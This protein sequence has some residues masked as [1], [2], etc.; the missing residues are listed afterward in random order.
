MGKIFNKFDSFSIKIDTLTFQID[1]FRIDI[2]VNATYF[3]L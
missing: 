3:I 2:F 1:K